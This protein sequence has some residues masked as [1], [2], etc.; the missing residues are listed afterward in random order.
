MQ[1]VGS[2]PDGIAINPRTRTVYVA[3]GY[4]PG[5]MSIFTAGH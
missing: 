3:N 4:L 5:S 1:A 2:G